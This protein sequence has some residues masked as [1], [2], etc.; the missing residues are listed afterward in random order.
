M[1]LVVSSLICELFSLCLKKAYCTTVCLGLAN[2]VRKK[3]QR[4]ILGWTVPFRTEMNKNTWKSSKCS[5]CWVQIL[6]VMS[7]C[8]G[9][10][11]SPSPSQWLSCTQEV[12][13]PHPLL[14]SYHSFLTAQLVLMCPQQWKA[15][16]ISAAAIL[17]WM[18]N[19][20]WKMSEKGKLHYTFD[21]MNE[22][23]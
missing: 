14:A 22:I 10:H 4:L 19:V 15:Q 5:Q 12:G 7:P 11:V 17:G 20:P 16:C 1:Y 2:K 8:T 6:E 23:Q 21:M 3:K 18:W 9:A 13:I